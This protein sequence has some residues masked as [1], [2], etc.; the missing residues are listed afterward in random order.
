[1]RLLPLIAV[2]AAAV[3]LLVVPPTVAQTP[4]PDD[5]VR[6]FDGCNTCARNPSGPVVCTQRKCAETKPAVCLQRLGERRAMPADCAVW[7]DGCNTC[8]RSAN[9]HLRCT[10]RYCST[11]GPSRCVRKIGEKP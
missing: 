5:C 1:M 3:V 7:Y 10:R 2:A 9:G 11:R 6:W 8:T 4:I